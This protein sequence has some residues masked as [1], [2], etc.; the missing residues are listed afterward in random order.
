MANNPN[1]EPP[2]P[3]PKQ[4]GKNYPLIGMTPEGYA[5]CTESVNSELTA[6]QEAAKTLNVS[7]TKLIGGRL[8]L[9][10]P[11]RPN[12]Q[13]KSSGVGYDAALEPILWRNLI[14]EIDLGH[15]FFSSSPVRLWY[16]KLATVS[17]WLFSGV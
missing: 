13:L 8:K 3:C 12:Q 2:C 10:G 4:S 1:L 7:S 9:L 6:T 11:S 16:P 14:P 15:F 5:R 17:S